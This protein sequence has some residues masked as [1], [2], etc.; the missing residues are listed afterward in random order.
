MARKIIYDTD[1]GWMNDDCMA[2]IFALKSADI[3]VLGITP[4][5]G[6]FDL[7]YEMAC[8]LRLMELLGHEHVPVC[9]GF[10]RPLIHQRS[11]YADKVWGRWAL[12]ESVHDIPPSMPKLNADPRHAV[13]FIAET[14]LAQPGEVSIV[15]VGPLTNVAVAMRM[16]PQII[17]AVAEIVIM[18]GA[19]GRLP[20]GSGNVTP[21]AE[22]NFW[23]D[24]EAA[25]IVMGSGAEITL[26]PL[27]VC[28]RSRFSHAMYQRIIAPGSDYPE[29]A[30]LFRRYIGPRFADA[31]LDRREP[32]LYYG[33]YDH[34]CLAWLIDPDIFSCERMCVEVSVQQ[35]LDYGASHGYIKGAYVSGNEALPIESDL[36]AVNVAYDIDF[37]RLVEIYVDAITIR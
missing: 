11:P 10:D 19:I 32:V 23:V 20:R 12:H 6:N 15:A 34:A 28:R 30:D 14:V 31:E 26:M 9:R 13:D 21:A 22:F 4:V 37:D 17:D 2:A 7:N 35:G 5:M 3:E 18:G 8:A 36:E 24:P 25:A 29:V 33:V 27:N 16:Y 1:I